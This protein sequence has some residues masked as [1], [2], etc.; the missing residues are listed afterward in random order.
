LDSEDLEKA[1]KFFAPPP[2]PEKQV[3]F[4][5]P[6]DYDGKKE[7][8][9]RVEP[10]RERK[11]NEYT[12]LF[13][14]EENPLDLESYYYH[15][16]RRGKEWLD[17][18]VDR[19][20]KETQLDYDPLVNPPYGL[21]ISEPSSFLHKPERTHEMVWAMGVDKD[22]A[23]RVED[24]TRFHKWLEDGKRFTKPQPLSHYFQGMT[25]DEWRELVRDKLIR[26]PGARSDVKDQGNFLGW[27]GPRFRQAKNDTYVDAAY[28][29]K[30]DQPPVSVRHGKVRWIAKDIREYEKKHK[31]H[32]SK[33]RQTNIFPQRPE[34]ESEDDG[35]IAPDYSLS[36]VPKHW[37]DPYQ[38]RQLEMYKKMTPEERKKRPA[39]EM[40]QFHHKNR[41]DAVRRVNE[42]NR[43]V[44]ELIRRSRRR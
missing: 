31:K 25:S 28:F 32:R 12:G 10:K 39:W 20:R 35:D 16:Y 6:A 42:E 4:G 24:S 5:L 26:V 41:E 13:D 21:T 30:P 33:I 1:R 2:V 15:G 23:K 40:R 17:T 22:F 11:Y 3:K 37:R 27:L 18:M 7:E 8:M 43:K 9:K 38:D 36:Q 19:L 29:A 44:N 14:D 34:P